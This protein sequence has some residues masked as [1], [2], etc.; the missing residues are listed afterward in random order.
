METSLLLSIIALVISVICFVGNVAVIGML[1]V[2]SELVRDE[3]K[4]ES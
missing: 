1:V 4:Q 3:R 2:I